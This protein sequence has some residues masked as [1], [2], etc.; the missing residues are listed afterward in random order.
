MLVGL[1]GWSIGELNRKRLGSGPWSG[2]ADALILAASM[3]ANDLLVSRPEPEIGNSPA[4]FGGSAVRPAAPRNGGVNRLTALD[5]MDILLFQFLIL[6][7]SDIKK[8][9]W[10]GGLGSF[11]GSP[12]HGV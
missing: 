12:F 4:G 10:L 6:I 5:V 8:I 9:H 1:G 7:D 3:I 2:P 11:S